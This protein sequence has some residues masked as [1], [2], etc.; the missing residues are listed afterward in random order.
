MRH[1][2][3]TKAKRVVGFRLPIAEDRML[4][5]AAKKQG[6]KPAAHAAA[7]VI[8]GLHRGQQK[9]TRSGMEVTLTRLRVELRETLRTMLRA[10]GWPE[11]EV[12]DA[13]ADIFGES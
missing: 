2:R 4:D 7:L 9:P 11:P 12:D 1:R 8:E 13:V 3:S 6:A 10:T 5:E